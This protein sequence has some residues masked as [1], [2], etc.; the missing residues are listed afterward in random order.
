M[1]AIGSLRKRSGLIATIVGISLMAFVLTGLFESGFQFFGED[2]HV[3]VIN[4]TKIAY[5]EYRTEYD[6]N[7]V[8]QMEKSQTSNLDDQSAEMVSNTTWETFIRK[9]VLLPEFH[10]SGIQVSDREM[11][12]IFFGNP[13]DQMIV[14]AFTDQQTGKVN[15]N[16]IDANGNLSGQR[17]KEYIDKISTDPQSASYWAQWNEFERSVRDNKLQTKYFTMLKKGLQVTTSYAK[18]DYKNSQTS[19]KFRYVLKRYQSVPDSTITVTDEEMQK[20]YN[21]NK[22]RFKQDPSCKVD[23]VV[24]DVFPS[25]EDKKHA[26][27][28]MDR[29]AAEFVKTKEDSAFVVRESETGLF[30]NNF[31][32]KAQLNPAIAGDSLLI[33]GEKGYVAKPYLDGSI[34]KVSKLVDLKTSPDSA[35]VRHILINWAGGP[36]SAPTV[37]RTKEQAKKMADSLMNALKAKK[38]QF[39]DY[40]LKYSADS[41]SVTDM[42]PKDP[43]KKTKKKREDLGAYKWF[44]EG[45]MVPE[46]Q[47]AAF[48]GKKG[49]LSVVETMYGYHIIEVLD[50]G[51]ESKRFKIATVERTTEPSSETRQEMYNQALDFIGAYSATPELFE[52][53]IQEKGLNKRTAEQLKST[54]KQVPGLEGAKDMVRWAFTSEQGMVSKEPFAYKNKYVVA[55]L[56]E[57]RSKGFASMEQKKVEVEIGA[58]RDKKAQMF[59]DEFTKAGASNIDAVGKKM[60][61]VVD[62][63]P[64]I[65]FNDFSVPALGRELTLLGTVFAL[66]PGALSK[67]IKGEQGVYIVIVEKVTPAPEAKDYDAQKKNLRS[68]LQ[69]RVDGQVYNILKEKAEV[70]DNRFKFE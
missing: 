30:D 59:K 54:D 63:V 6:S 12:E 34:W 58:K 57:V 49:D 22:A 37:T 11:A 7:A 28:D 33:N 8:K 29:I 44:K 35:S 14:P 4:G 5:E 21:E 41:G 24:F 62:S 31:L 53:G 3:G 36:S 50:K 45:M 16:F 43:K 65:R 13:P 27:T 9:L 1:A 40:V 15:E 69:M 51:A 48:L 2:N 56:T 47:N 61:L 39:P 55:L 38:G 42:D 10:S 32:K 26:Q 70:E 17:I 67:P 64:S 18:Q 60:D 66:K 46:F 68:N 20:F 19:V 23:F 52:K 25:E